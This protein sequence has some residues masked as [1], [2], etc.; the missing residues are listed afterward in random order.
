M[1]KL[2]ALGTLLGCL[3][4]STASAAVTT[5]DVSSGVFPDV[6]DPAWTLV[7]DF[8]PVGPVLSGQGL[9]LGTSLF[10]AMAYVQSGAELNFQATL[11]INATMQLGDNTES[12]VNFRAPAGITFATPGNAINF[13]WIDDG[14][15]FL[16]TTGDVRGPSVNVATR[17]TKHDYRI[18]VLGVTSGSV[19]NVYYDGAPT[20]I[21]TG[22][23]FTPASP[24][25]AAINFGAQT[26]AARGISVWTHFSHDAAPVTI[27]APVS[28]PVL[29]NPAAIA[30]FFALGLVAVGAA[31]RAIP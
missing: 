21:L 1:S 29:G 15:I 10:G 4:T 11:E 27:P 26:G 25:P 5:W 31:R 13:L 2:I 17:D 16:N 30:L 19:I 18:E 22:A 28:V 24:T 7:N 9:S 8:S 6:V 23:L 20:P 12:L 14:E 3:V